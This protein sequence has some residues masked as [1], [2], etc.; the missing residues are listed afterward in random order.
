MSEGPLP[1]SILVIGSGAASV[2]VAAEVRR[3]GY[4]RAVTILGEEAGEPYDRPPL[5]KQVL[6]GS[7]DV[8]KVYLLS[9]RRRREIDA[10]WLLGCQASSLDVARK[11]VTV[12]DGSE[13][14]Y[15]AAVIATGV[16]P[17]TLRTHDLTNI[18]VLRTLD[19]ALALKSALVPGAQLVVIGGGFLGLEAA[20]TARQLGSEVTVVEPLESP[21]AGRLG[22]AAADK[23]LQ[24]HR[25]R[26][27]RVITGVGVETIH[28]RNAEPTF[29][30]AGSSG[31][32]HEPVP[33]RVVKLTNGDELA[34][35][36]ILVAIGCVP[37]VEWLEG[38]GLEIDDGVVCDEFGRAGRDVWAA[39][40]VARW[41]HA[42][43]GRH[44]RL[45]HRM[46][47]NEHG[48][49]VARGILGERA[50]FSPIPYFWTDHYDAKIQVWGVVPEHGV[51]ELREGNFYEDTFV[52]AF[53]DPVADRVVGA[54][55]WN[56]RAR[57]LA[58][59]DEIAAAW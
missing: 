39:G 43:L 37:N 13:L 6:A 21:L 59:R 27:V 55:G 51:A 19:D 14:S 58:Y 17:R 38:S 44:V 18:H 56:A 48:R 25:D 29:P 1:A 57:I 12:S 16:R 40:D 54:L 26:G 30:F 52:V 36:T 33:A 5:S 53:R 11:I 23:L 31:E 15:G 3:A 42:R 20:A 50:S 34:A 10:T 47:A 49:A 41:M 24:L 46:N 22:S 35:D 4:D 9:K 8:H 2:S 45:E 7:W 32:P 28:G